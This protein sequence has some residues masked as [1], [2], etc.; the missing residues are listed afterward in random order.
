MATREKSDNCDRP[1]SS[2]Y[3][4]YSLLYNYV[5]S[6]VWQLRHVVAPATSNYFILT[7]D[8][9]EK[10]KVSSRLRIFCVFY[11]R[12]RFLCKTNTGVTRHLLC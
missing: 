6:Q 12:M 7:F 3:A 8:F 2:Y 5:L 1:S 4:I 9:F 10:A 11:I